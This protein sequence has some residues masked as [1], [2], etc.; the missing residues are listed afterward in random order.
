[1]SAIRRRARLSPSR[2]AWVQA[3]LDGTAPPKDSPEWRE[4]LAWEFFGHEI[5]GLPLGDSPAGRALLRR[6]GIYPRY[7]AAEIAQMP[8]AMRN[9]L[10]DYDGEDAAL[11]EFL[12]S[13]VS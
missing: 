5:R 1:M 10:P 8:P 4:V 3:M 11:N 6:C 2:A 12:T 13:R 9:G 7:T